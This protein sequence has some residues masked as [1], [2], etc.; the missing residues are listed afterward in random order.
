MTVAALYIIALAMVAVAWLRAWQRFS[1]AA[2]R[3]EQLRQLHR[4]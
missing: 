3:L 1:K 4:Q 2:R